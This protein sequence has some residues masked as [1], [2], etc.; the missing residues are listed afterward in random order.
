MVLVV[1]SL[2]LK[3]IVLVYLKFSLFINKY[4]TLEYRS[5]NC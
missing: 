1:Y 3:F 5:K 2:I 4:K